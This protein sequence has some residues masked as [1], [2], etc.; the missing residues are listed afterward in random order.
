MTIFYPDISAFQG[1]IS[2]FGAVAVCAKATE[3]TGWTSSNYAWQKAEAARRGAFFFAYHFLHAGNA[4]AQA[5]HC[6]NVVGKTPLMLDFEP[7]STHPSVSD[8]LAFVDK[9]R[10]L[11]GIVNLLYLPHWY[12]QQLGSPTL[13]GFVSR[14]MSL[15][16]S[17]YVSYSDSGPGW[18]GYGGMDVAIWQFSSSFSFNGQR[19]DF[20]AFKGTVAQLVALVGGKVTP[21]KPEDLILK[22]GDSGDAV[23]YLQGRL[24]VWNVAHPALAIDGVFGSATG[25]AVGEM[26]KEHGLTVDRIV[27]PATWA[28]LDKTPSVDPP[29]PPSNTFAAP[30]GLALAGKL[31]SIGIKWTA[32]PDVNGVPP[33]GY[34][35]QCYQ[36]NGVK[37]GE[38]VVDGTSA[39]FDNL[40]PRM[41]V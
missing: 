26:Q 10:A 27:G 28:E 1:N 14:G 32:V 9:F 11:G 5:Q 18:A 13:S 33:T 3:G 25:D 41:A 40:S 8:A 24:N 38:Q 6:F 34:T 35:A 19:V 22:Q 36:M 7:S 31:V 15:V 37:V 39:R 21:M 29:P 12:W 2:L 16:S 20:N 30:T 4:A 23:K 17:D